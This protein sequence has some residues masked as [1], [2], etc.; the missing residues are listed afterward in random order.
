MSEPPAAAP[1]VVECAA[2]GRVNLIGEHTD[3]NDGLVLPMPIPQQTHVRLTRR[4]DRRVLLAS[5]GAP[6]A[7]YV[8]GE[9]RKTGGWADYV[10]GLTSELLKRGFAIGG[11]EASLTSQ[12]PIGA[13][14]S[15]SAALEVA[16]LRALRQAFCLTLDDMTI[17]RL[18]QLSEVEFVGAPI[19][20][21]DQMV[22]SLGTQG[23]ALFIDIRSEQTRLVSLPPA[24]ELVV[25]ASGVT[26][27]HGTGGYRQRREECER[28]C[29]QL[30][31]R[32]LRDVSLAQLR[33]AKGLDPLLRR[34]AQHVVSENERVE[35]TVEA[36]EGG[37]LP[38][39]RALFAA[40]HASMRDDYEVS[41]PQIDLLVD[42]GMAQAGIVA[43]R[44]TGGGFGGSVVML[45]ERGAGLA[46]AR[47]IT[48]RYEAQTKLQ[49]AILL[50]VAAP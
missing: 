21:M 1:Q 31:V 39:L 13:G 11:F 14:L 17:A 47:E 44:L 48:A 19:G 41:V 15:S 22:S 46:A 4:D 35:R 45:A 12:V 9:E 5:D 16:V 36:L 8:L 6:P 33:D 42:L 2:P 50:P 26:H 40:S 34:R 18:G 25:I 28:A 30:G 32:S 3:Y 20:I 7:S 37:D 10:Q 43:A 23:S 24:L 27:A 29:Q 38:T 49:A